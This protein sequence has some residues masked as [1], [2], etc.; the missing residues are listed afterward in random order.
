M[1]G[2]RIV[3]TGPLIAPFGASLHGRS[4]RPSVS[5]SADALDLRSVIA[6]AMDGCR[7]PPRAGA[8]HAALHRSKTARSSRL[9]GFFTRRRGR[10]YPGNL[11]TNW[12]AQTEVYQ[13]RRADRRRKQL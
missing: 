11:Q 13:I 6:L 2:N 5:E 1:S 8:R 3:V 9:Q 7:A 4:K 12:G 10:H